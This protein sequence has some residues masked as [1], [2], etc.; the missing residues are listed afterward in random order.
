M[1]AW[2]SS[3]L[4]RHSAILDFSD[5]SSLN[6]PALWLRLLRINLDVSLNPPDGQVGGIRNPYGSGFL[7][8]TVLGGVKHEITRR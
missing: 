7:N 3:R 1:F 8:T 4:A 6:A 2:L 5:N